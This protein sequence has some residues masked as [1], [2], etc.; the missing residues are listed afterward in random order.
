VPGSGEEWYLELVRQHVGLEVDVLDVACGHGEL[1]LEIAAQCRTLVGYDRQPA[2]I[3]LGQTDGG[4]EARR[5]RE[6][7]LR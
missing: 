5:Q 1:S 7:H 3:E 2:W 6:V 4:R